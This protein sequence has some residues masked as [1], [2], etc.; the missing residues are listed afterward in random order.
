MEYA[1]LNEIS[2]QKT[3]GLFIIQREETSH[4]E[5]GSL[6]WQFYKQ[7]CIITERLIYSL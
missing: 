1:Q 7:K 5:M 2:S 3:K 4:K 6:H